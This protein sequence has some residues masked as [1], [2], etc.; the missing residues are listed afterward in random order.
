[1]NK[2]IASS[3]FQYILKK[4]LKDKWLYIILFP[5]ILYFVIFKYGAIYGLAIAFMDY[6]PFRGMKSP[7]VGFEQFERLFHDP[8]FRLIFRNTFALA[9]YNIV[10]FFPFPIILSLLLNELRNQHFKNAVQALIYIPH[11]ISWPVVVSLCYLLFTPANG[12]VNKILNEI[13]ISP[14]NPLMSPTA[15]RPMVILMQTWKESGWGT[16]IFLAALSSVNVELYEAATI[17]GANRFQQMIHVTFPAI[18]GTI[19]TML[20]LRMGSFMDSGFE[21]IYLLLNSLNRS[22]GEVFDTYTYTAGL[23]NG[24]F[25][26][27]TAVGLF[28][29]VI[30]LVMVVS[31]NIIA[32]RAGEEGVY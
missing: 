21:Q 5:G 1:M 12:F 23:L 22:V 3:N 32:K 28:K 30:S 11:F 2:S 26:Y 25:S 17:D 10:F 6:S 15:F 9:V 7:F 20:I 18:K 14:I 31:V 13:G 29:S 16:I 27:S 8:N 19:V 4:I 24:Q